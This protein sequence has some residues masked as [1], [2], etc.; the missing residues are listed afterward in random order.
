MVTFCLT[1]YLRSSEH[2]CINAIQS[3]GHWA[4]LGS[5]LGDGHCS[6]GAQSPE[7]RPP[8]APLP[9][10]GPGPGPG[11][12]GNPGSR[13]IHLTFPPRLPDIL[14]VADSHLWPLQKL[15]CNCPSIKA[16]TVSLAHQTLS[17]GH[18]KMGD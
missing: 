16:F 5:S 7:H 3:C 18:R 15:K 6:T 1:V 12:G 8:P 9:A 2:W 17:L 11:T 10:G 13:E 14:I 4:A